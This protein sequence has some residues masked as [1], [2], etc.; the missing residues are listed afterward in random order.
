ME[1]GNPNGQKM[2]KIRIIPRKIP[3]Q[4]QKIVQAT[5]PIRKITLHTSSGTVKCD[6]KI[7]SEFEIK[8]FV[9]NMETFRVVHD[10]GDTNAEDI[11]TADANA[12]DEY[13]KERGADQ[14]LD[15]EAAEEGEE[16]KEEYVEYSGN[17]SVG[18]YPVNISQF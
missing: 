17:I 11:N 18:E 3:P 15:A 1:S 16:D 5:I 6:S 8:T 9:G 10:A 2:L 13:D 14:F 12:E 4:K 7:N